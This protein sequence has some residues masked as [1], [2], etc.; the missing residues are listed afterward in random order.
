[1]K[2][3]I[4]T[5]H[6]G[7]NYGGVLQ[8]YALQQVLFNLGHE[9]QVI[10]YI[11]SYRIKQFL[12][13]CRSCF[14]QRGLTGIKSLFL[15]LK[16]SISCRKVF[17]CFTSKY[18]NLTK[19]INDIRSLR[20]L[21]FDVIIVGSDQVWN[22]S[23]HKS[24]IY[25]LYW[26]EGMKCK[27]YSYAACCGQNKIDDYYRETLVKE[28]NDFDGIS[29]RSFETACFVKN[30]IGETPIVV[31][32]PTMLYDFSEFKTQR[33]N[34]L[35]IAYILGNDINGGN[36][37]VIEKIR[38]KYSKY[39]IYALIIGDHFINPCDWADKV[40]YNVSPSEWVDLIYNSAFVYTDSFHGSIFAMKFGKPLIAYYTS[41]VSG[42][43]FEDL[44]KSY[45]M[46]NIITH[47][48]Q[49]DRILISNDEMNYNYLER[50][51]SNIE[52]SM[53]FLNNI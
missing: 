3:G 7:S 24:P 30:L 46:R 26:T 2:I 1:M 42:K 35:I 21:D 8:C 23:Q 48:D 51:K 37:V 11:P 53:K 12:I 34:K 15:Y 52:L 39:K 32:D 4:L 18:L 40:L 27:K 31:C 13:V 45:N 20:Q 36:N 22:Q 43:R 29:V 41:P 49:V 17:N 14:K 38:A 50:V 47:A 25:F 16:Y 5:F 9:V 19:E 6:Y 44:G 33:K 10:N 28:L